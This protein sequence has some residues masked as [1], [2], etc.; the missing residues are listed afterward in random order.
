M[1]VSGDPTEDILAT[2]KIVAVYK[3]GAE[4]DRAKVPA[5]DG[6]RAGFGLAARNGGA[7]TRAAVRV[8]G[9]RRAGCCTMA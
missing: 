1:L 3:N 8:V 2:R 5:V 9:P 4:L 7:R 6:L